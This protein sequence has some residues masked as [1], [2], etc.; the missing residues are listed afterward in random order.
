MSFE[1]LYFVM[2]NFSVGIKN[3][4]FKLFMLMLFMIYGPIAFVPQKRLV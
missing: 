3:N 1:F 4:S 2:W